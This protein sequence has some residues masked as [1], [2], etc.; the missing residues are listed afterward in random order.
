MVLREVQDIRDALVLERSKNNGNWLDLVR[1]RPNRRR[2]AV[3]VVLSLATQFVGNGV[4]Q[5][6]LVPVLRQVGI[7]KPAQSA[8]INGGLAV[9]N[10]MAAIA[11]ASLVERV[12]RRKLILTSVAGMLSCF[13][14]VTALS[15]S[16]ATTR[17]A[18]VGLGIVPFIYLFMGFYSIALTPLPFLYV[19]EISPLSLRVKMLSLFLIVSNIGLTFNNFV[20][21]IALAAIAWKYYF[22]YVGALV[23]FGTFFFFIIRETRGLTVEEAALVYEDDE[24]R[25]ALAASHQEAVQPVDVASVI[26]KDDKQSVHQVEYKS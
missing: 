18:N 26:D 13:I 25:E 21:P 24:V 4:V 17:N 12:G 8:G 15:G 11:G 3:V 23:G 7:S 20:N 9:F 19:P 2:T 6:F 16:Y 1:T 5:Y 10:F 22:V 14:I